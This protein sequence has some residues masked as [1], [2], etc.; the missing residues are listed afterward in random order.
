MKKKEIAQDKLWMFERSFLKTVITLFY[1]DWGRR[2]KVIIAHFQDK[3]KQTSKTNIKIKTFFI[4]KYE[5][6]L[7]FIFEERL[8]TL[9]LRFSILKINNEQNLINLTT[10]F[11]PK[12][13][14][15]KIVS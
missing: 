14:K 2:K 1:C 9:Y 3:S 12:F 10:I 4:A 6:R 5:K 13:L 15:K 7:Q 11:N 8:I